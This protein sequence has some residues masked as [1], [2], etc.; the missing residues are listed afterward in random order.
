VC[1]MPGMQGLGTALL[2]GGS[3]G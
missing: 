2:A 1:L 3:I